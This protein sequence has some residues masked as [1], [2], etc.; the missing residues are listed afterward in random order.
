[1]LPFAA[2]ANMGLFSNSRLQSNQDVSD[3]M[4]GLADQVGT[5]AAQAQG[6]VEAGVAQGMSL[7][8]DGQAKYTQ[9]KD[10]TVEK[11]KEAEALK[12]TL[13]D[14]DTPPLAKA[15]ALFKFLLPVLGLVWK[16]ACCLLPLYVKLFEW[17]H[18]FYT[19]AP[20]KL[21]TMVF[22]V[23]LCFFGGTFVASLAAI[24]AFI[25][26]GGERLWA[27][28]VYVYEQTL[29]V[30]KA[31][32]KDEEKGGGLKDALEG[33]ADGQL[34]GPELAQRKVFLVMQTV[35]EP[36]RLENAV[37]SLWSAY[38]AVLATLSMQF[39]QIAALALG[40]AST[41]KPLVSR[42]ATP[43]LEWAV[44]PSL[45]HW[46]GSIINITLNFA[47]MSIA[48][49]L[50]MIIASIYSGLRG[51]KL[52]AEALLGLLD[53]FG[54]VSRIPWEGCRKAF[55]PE[56]SFLDEAIAYALAAAGIYS[57]IFSGFAI[58][59]PFDLVLMPLTWV[60]LFLRYQITFGSG[61]STQAQG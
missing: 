7:A 5:A 31:H 60:E 26:M 53:D 28:L 45:V 22:G 12:S 51:G 40:M 15:L 49:Y 3:N 58:A 48:W 27:D 36:G 59:F 54:L 52:F 21:V 44:D 1:M 32:E 9:L 37:G 4:S 13:T 19:W 35:R 30:Y 24:E 43:A 16:L 8:A 18:F 38:V 61:A 14:K 10:G 50:Q 42:V 56:T 20:K 57:Q 46:I 17:L 25:N 55:D 29:V 2:F 33:A 47:A 11:L 23:A 6:Q 34:P 39:A 41:V